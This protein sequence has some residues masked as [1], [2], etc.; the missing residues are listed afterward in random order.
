MQLFHNRNFNNFVCNIS[1]VKKTRHRVEVEEYLLLL[2]KKA[3]RALVAPS[4]F[5]LSSYLHRFYKQKA[6]ILIDEYDTPIYE[7]YLK[8][9]YK[10][11]VDFLRRLLGNT[12]KGN[13]CLQKGVL[14]GILRVFKESMFSDLN[15]MKVHSVLSEKFNTC[16]GF[17]GLAHYH[18]KQNNRLIC[19]NS[20]PS[21]LN[22]MHIFIACEAGSKAFPG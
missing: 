12:L 14:T 17:T 19:L 5:L 13:A 2:N 3:D 10:E 18:H 22:H 15:N 8:G 4:L 9:F 1:A 7:A 21:A 11:A 6:I 20:K 16:F